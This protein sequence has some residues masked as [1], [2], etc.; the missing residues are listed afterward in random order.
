MRNLKISKLD[1]ALS[2]FWQLARHWQ[3]G[4][5]AKLEMSCEAGSLHIQLN[6][7]LGNSDL[8]HFHRPSA[9]PCK[10]K[11]PSQLRRQECRRHAAK[12]DVEEAKSKQSLSAERSLLLENKLRIPKKYS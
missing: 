1:V 6:A 10:R 3:Q 8:L 7:K 4:K 9:P 11:S 5:A 2:S 12:T